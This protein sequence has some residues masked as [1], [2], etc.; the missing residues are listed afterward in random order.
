MNCI[1]KEEELLKQN[2]VHKLLCGYEIPYKDHN[3]AHNSLIS[4]GYANFSG[5][6]MSKNWKTRSW[7]PDSFYNPPKPILSRWEILD[8]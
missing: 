6:M 2:I 3:S 7:K 1:K 5:G 4:A 8:L